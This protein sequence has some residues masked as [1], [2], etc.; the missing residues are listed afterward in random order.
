MAEPIHRDLKARAE[1]FAGLHRRLG[2]V[3]LH[4]IGM[5]PPPGTATEADVLRHLDAIDKRTYELLEETLVEKAMGFR[6]SMIGALLIEEIRRFVRMHKLG[7]VAGAN[8]PFRLTAG[9]IRIPDISFIP[10][11]AIPESMT[12]VERLT[13][14]PPILTVEVLSDSNSRSEIDLKLQHFFAKQCQLAW[15]I[16]PTRR[17][18]IIYKSMNDCTELTE[19][20]ELD[21]GSVLPGFRLKL[22]DV[23]AAGELQR[24]N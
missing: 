16:D 24:P 19:L 8:G 13:T 17:I 9:V 10:W 4:R 1:D 7:I 2:E 20:D 23:F 5:D 6:E 15:V 3:P 22:S 11:S 18:A 12:A 21:G 14:L